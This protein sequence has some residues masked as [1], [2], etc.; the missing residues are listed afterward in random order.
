MKKYISRF[1]FIV[2]VQ[3][4][5]PNNCAIASYNGITCIN[6]IRNIK[7]SELERIFFSKLVEL[8]VP[9]SIECNRR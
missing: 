5:Y 9:I 6:I 4:S 8:G 7:E 1:E 3:K 2:G